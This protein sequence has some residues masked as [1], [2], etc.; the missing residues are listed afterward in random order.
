MCATV[1]PL[2]DYDPNDSV[3]PSV[4]GYGRIG[5][6]IYAWMKCWLASETTSATQLAMAPP[7]VKNPPYASR[8]LDDSPAGARQ[9]N[10]TG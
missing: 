6:S 5:E 3:H 10:L 1:Y 2:D 9:V 8:G 4:A 7:A